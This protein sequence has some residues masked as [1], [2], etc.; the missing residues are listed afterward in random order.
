MRRRI[1]LVVLGCVAMLSGCGRPAS[2]VVPS[3]I[4][5]IASRQPTAQVE[6]FGPFFSSSSPPDEA[7][8]RQM[9]SWSSDSGRWTTGPRYCTCWPSDLQEP[10]GFSLCV[11]EW[12]DV[13]VEANLRYYTRPSRVGIVVRARNPNDAYV[14]VISQTEEQ[15]C[16]WQTRSGGEDADTQAPERWSD[17]IDPR[18]LAL[19]QGDGTQVVVARVRVE[20][21]GNRLVGYVNALEASVLENAPVRSGRIGLYMRSDGTEQSWADVIIHAP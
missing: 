19:P 2:T 14:F 21:V 12:T 18:P 20:A 4:P 10:E 5:T 13:I 11:G 3:P 16:Y 17:P 7:C 9:E 6:T 1:G 15:R 8:A